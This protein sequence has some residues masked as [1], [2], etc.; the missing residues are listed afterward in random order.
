[1][2]YFGILALL[3]MLV[4]FSRG[5]MVNRIVLGVSRNKN[6]SRVF[7]VNRDIFKGGS[8]KPMP[9]IDELAKQQKLRAAVDGESPGIW[10]VLDETLE[11]PCEFIMKVI[12][13][14]DF[15]FVNDVL[16]IV[17]APLE[18]NPNTI[19]YT[20]KVTTG[21]KYLSITLKPIWQDSS[22]IESVYNLLSK[23]P[24]IKF[25]L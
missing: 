12:G 18:Q 10:K 14:N 17:A 13:E 25:V 9:S 16:D 21:G 19:N 24:R 11:F 23:D 5:L 6:N 1:M 7:G 15:S 8:P 22:Q 4:S 3:S 20:T 2:T